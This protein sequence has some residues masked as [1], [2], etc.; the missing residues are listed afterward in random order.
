MREHYLNGTQILAEAFS[1]EDGALK[2]IPSANT[3]FAVSLDAAD[4]DNVTT[5]PDN[6]VVSAESGAVSCVGMKTICLF[7]SGVVSV[8]PSDEGEDFVTLNLLE[9]VPTSI[10]ARRVKLTGTGKAV[11]QAV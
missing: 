8:S 3:Q 1:V 5:K 2:F 4:G 9:L 11:M 6:G 7:G 10:C